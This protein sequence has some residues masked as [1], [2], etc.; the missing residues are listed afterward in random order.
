MSL[1]RSGAIEGYE[2]L[3]K[4]LGGNPVV[5]LAHVDLTPAQLHNSNNYISYRKMAELL[6]ITSESCNAPLFGLLLAQRQTSSI[7]GDMTMS[8][9]QQPSL[10]IAIDN[11]RRYLYLHARGAHLEV[12]AEGEMTLLRLALEVPSAY[13]LAQTMQ[14]S[15]A[16]LA[17]FMADLLG[18]NQPGFALLLQQPRPIGPVDLVNPTHLARVQFDCAVDGIRIPSTWLARQPRH[19]EEFLL[20]HYHNYLQSLQQR[21]P[22]K[23]SDQ[24]KDIIGQLL[25]HGECNVDRVAAT[26]DLHPRVL[27]QRL[28]HRGDSY[29]ELLRETRQEIA[30]QHLRYRSLPITELA[31]KLGYA[32]GSVFSRSFKQWTGLSPRQWQQRHA[33]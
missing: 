7:L 12:E 1:V 23:L 15:V 9:F 2:K 19:N 30:E 8:A 24:V 5:L 18:M 17:N 10:Q 26:L 21:Y 28:H 13:G 6:E 27:Q 3:T 4:L 20:N 25:P 14:L 22:D 29:G 11:L 31:F 16:Q 33:S 32:E